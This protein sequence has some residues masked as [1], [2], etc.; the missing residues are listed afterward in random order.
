MTNQPAPGPV[1]GR[2][3][4]KLPA[5]LQTT[6]SNFA[7]ITHSASEIVIDLAQVM[8]QVPEAR[9]QA[10]ILMTPLN[11]KLFLRALGDNLGR[12]EAQFGTIATPEGSTLADTLFRPSPEPGPEK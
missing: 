9:V 3:T 11:A 1:G 8:P 6:Y 12:Y 5:D 7:V 10:R 2:V 4:V